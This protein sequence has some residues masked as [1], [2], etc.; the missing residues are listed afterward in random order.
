MLTVFALE[1]ILTTMVDNMIQIMSN[2][3]LSEYESRTYRSLLIDNPVTAYEAAGNAGIPTSKIYQVLAKL[4][5]KG[6]VLEVREK[7]K[8]LFVPQS[9]DDFME[10]ISTKT[11]EDLAKLKKEGARLE[12][13]PEITYLFNI[14]DSEHFK[15]V[16]HTMIGKTTKSLL[17]STGQEEYDAFLPLLGDFKDIRLSIVLF[18]ATKTPVG[19]LFTHPIA[20]TIFGEKGGRGFTMVRDSKEALMVTIGEHE[21]SGAWSKNPG[22]VAMAED[23]I[24]HDIYI[25]KIVKRF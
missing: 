8:K 7:N 23:Y 25:M 2:F 10:R 17:I 24:K 20:D 18:G 6:I 12:V 3:G 5:E 13:K 14:N 16:V 9:L 15:E 4:K 22:F 21:T 11:S 19:T 1:F